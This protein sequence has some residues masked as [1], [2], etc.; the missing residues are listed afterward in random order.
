VTPAQAFSAIGRING[1]VVWTDSAGAVWAVK[2]DAP[3][4][5]RALYRSGAL[6]VSHSAIA[7]GCLSWSRPA[8]VAGT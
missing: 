3:E 6:L 8:A 7:M 1:K 4:N 5:A 2:L